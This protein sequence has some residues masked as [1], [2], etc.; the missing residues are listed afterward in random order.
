ML[1]LSCLESVDKKDITQLSGGEKQRV[2]IARAIYK[3]KPIILLDEATSALDNKLSEKIENTIFS[4]NKTILE[5]SHKKQH[6][7]ESFYTQTIVLQ[8]NK[9]I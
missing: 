8:K 2:G 5:I 3:N 6:S 7:A 4:M 9:E 1:K